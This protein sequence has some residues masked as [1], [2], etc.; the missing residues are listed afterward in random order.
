MTRMECGQHKQKSTECRF[1]KMSTGLRSGDPEPPSAD[2]DKYSLDIDALSSAAGLPSAVSVWNAA[3]SPYISH[4]AIIASVTANLGPMPGSAFLPDG[5]FG[6]ADGDAAINLDA[7]MVHD[8]VENPDSFD[9]SPAGPGLGDEIIFSIRQIV[10]PLDPDGYYAT[11]SELF[12]LY[13][14]GTTGPLF[15]GGHPW[16]HAYAI[17]T[18]SGGMPLPD[19]GQQRFAYDINAIEAVGEYAVP[20]PASMALVMVGLFGFGFRC[21]K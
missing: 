8:V 15:H 10:D 12:V 18:F 11:G 16:D 5:P 19:G 7:L 4:A 14:D 6:A 13:A 17:A 3:G 9:R 21:R 1:L 2:A 20:E